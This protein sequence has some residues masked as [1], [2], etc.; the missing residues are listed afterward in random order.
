MMDK[1]RL[2][3]LHKLVEKILRENKEARTDD[4]YLYARLV[5]IL[6]PETYYHSFHYVMTHSQ[7][8]GLPILDSVTR[9]RRK[10]L[11]EFPEL[12]IDEVQERR[13]ENEIV[14][15]EYFRQKLI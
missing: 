4:C 5:A 13:E 15:R 3:D 2:K 11:K 8:F 1:V 14:H 6:N 9:C 7:Q 12:R 10:V